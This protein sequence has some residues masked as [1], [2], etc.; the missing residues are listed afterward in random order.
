MCEPIDVGHV[1]AAVHFRSRLFT[2]G[3]IRQ[4]DAVG[5]RL[6]ARLATASRPLIQVNAI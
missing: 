5:S 4:L 3:H 2:F 6:R 1:P